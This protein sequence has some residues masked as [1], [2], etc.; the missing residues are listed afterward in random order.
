MSTFSLDQLGWSAFYSQHL[1]VDDLTAGYPGRV[2]STQRSGLTVLSEHGVA[3]VVVPSHLIDECGPITVGD[4]VM[5][6]QAA[7][8]VYRLI[9]RRS[10]LARMAAGADQR[11]Q[12]IAANLDALFIVTSCNQDFNL[13]RLERYLTLAFE[14]RV[15]PVILLTKADLCADSGTLVDQACTISRGSKVLALDATKPDVASA[16]AEWLTRGRTVAFAGSSGVGK[17]T[18]INTLL[19]GELQA[20]GGIR[21]HDGRGRHTTTSRQMFAL[22]GGA[23]VI[24]TP[25]MREIKLG[26]AESGVRAAFSDLEALARQCRFRDCNHRGDAGCALE[27]AVASGAL[28]ARRLNSYLKLQREVS[29]AARSERERRE[30]ERK[31]GRMARESV[32]R[33]ERNRKS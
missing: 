18:L 22:P 7:R 2:A 30:M 1:T 25:G 5:I 6:E 14:A 19:G 12:L 26:A 8:R 3:D 4:W 11:V 16:L 23:W 33:K 17:S 24:D 27:S 20:T 13:S 31:F 15:E 29:R 32:R 10:L 21:E 28:D 9:E